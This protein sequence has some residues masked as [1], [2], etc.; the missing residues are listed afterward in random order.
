MVVRLD[1]TATLESRLSG[2][3]DV[4]PVALRETMGRH[5]PIN[6]V[7]GYSQGAS[8]AQEAETDGTTGIDLDTV[9]P[10]Q[11]ARFTMWVVLPDA[12][13][14]TDPHPSEK[15]LGSQDWLMAIPV[16]QVNGHGVGE[17]VARGTRV[18]HC[19]EPVI[20]GESD[21]KY[22]AVVDD[23]PRAQHGECLEE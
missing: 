15:T 22:L 9:Q 7:M 12:V 17:Y 13:T 3:V 2:K 1:L 21:R 5:Q 14:P 18:V 11:S 10:H 20:G 6:F 19:H 23:T 16:P 8:C 4:F